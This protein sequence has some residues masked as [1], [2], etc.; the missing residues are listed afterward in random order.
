[1]KSSQK[2]FIKKTEVRYSLWGIIIGF[3]IIIYAE[4]VYYTKIG[5]NI[6]LALTFLPTM[7]FGLIKSCPPTSLCLYYGVDLAVFTAPIYLGILGFLIGLF[8][9]KLRKKKW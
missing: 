8:I 9:E 7:I 2:H 4:F 3:I 5:G 1:M 6:L